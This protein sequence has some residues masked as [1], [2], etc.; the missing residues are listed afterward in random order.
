MY[1]SLYTVVVQCC[2]T[3]WPINSIPV[4]DIMMISTVDITDSNNI[5]RGI[6]I[7]IG[8]I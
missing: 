5:I 2:M 8:M 4:H 6:M 7:F 1:M 3:R